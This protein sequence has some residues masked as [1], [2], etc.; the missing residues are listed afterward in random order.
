[1]LCNISQ[2]L[3]M[4][5]NISHLRGF[6]GIYSYLLRWENFLPATLL[7][8]RPKCSTAQWASQMHNPN[9]TLSPRSTPKHTHTHTCSRMFLFSFH[10]LTWHL[11]RTSSRMLNSSGKSK[12]FLSYYSSLGES[13]QTFTLGV[14]LPWVFHRCFLSGWGSSLQHAL[15]LFSDSINSPSNHM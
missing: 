5:C 4:L 11:A 6:T 7:N 9:R 3:G 12:T 8:F 13:F 2:Q 15:H 14:V 1:M 10:I